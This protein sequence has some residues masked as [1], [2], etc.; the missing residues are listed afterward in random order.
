MPEVM[1]TPATIR[2][3]SPLDIIPIPTFKDLLLSLRNSIDGNPQPASFVTMAIVT[4]TAERTRTFR[5]T[6]RKST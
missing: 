3:T 4:M 1:P 5:L 6:P 2:P